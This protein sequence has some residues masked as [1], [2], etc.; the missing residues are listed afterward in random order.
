MSDSGHES[1][2]PVR[3]EIERRARNRSSLASSAGSPTVEELER[4]AKLW[5]DECMAIC[6][7]LADTAGLPRVPS[8]GWRVCINVIKGKLEN[9]QDQR[10]AETPRRTE[11]Q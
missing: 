10:R 9:A 5:R 4:R 7:A 3:K 1:E 2:I 6:D 11:N 8:P